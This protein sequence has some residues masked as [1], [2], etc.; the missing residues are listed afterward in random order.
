[1]SNKKWIEIFS[2]GSIWEL[3]KVGN[4]LVGIRQENDADAYEEDELCDNGIST[5]ENRA[6]VMGLVFKEID[7]DN[8]QDN[9]IDADWLVKELE[10]WD[11]R[12]NILNNSYKFG[13]DNTEL[14]ITLWDDETITTEIN[15]GGDYSPETYNH[16]TRIIKCERVNVW[17]EFDDSPYQE[18]MESG[19]IDIFMLQQEATQWYID[20]FNLE[21]YIKSYSDIESE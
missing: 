18:K 2:D 1:M 13:E 6:K 20:N 21:L 5:P 12:N 3:E 10:D 19:E 15:F 11:L 4:R 7:P 8:S 14:W 9:G 17:D 16:I